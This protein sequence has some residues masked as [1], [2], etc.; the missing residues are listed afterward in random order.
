M[1]LLTTMTDYVMLASDVT[2][3]A[4]LLTQ[5]TAKCKNAQ[6]ESTG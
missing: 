3:L 5:I 6:L 1:W 4:K 2:M